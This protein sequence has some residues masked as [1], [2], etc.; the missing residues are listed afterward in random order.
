MNP[1]LMLSC[2]RLLASYQSTNRHV[3]DS[4]SHPSY[5]LIAEKIAASFF[6]RD[7]GVYCRF[8]IILS[9]A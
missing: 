6:Y 4:H 2:G 3:K 9:D 8:L 7:P 1:A 5:N